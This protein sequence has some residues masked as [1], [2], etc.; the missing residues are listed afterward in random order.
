MAKRR[1]PNRADDADDDAVTAAK[2]TKAPPKKRVARTKKAKEA[3]D[4]DGEDASTQ[5]QPLQPH[6]EAAEDAAGSINEDS[7]AEQKEEPRQKK[8]A[9]SKR[10][11]PPLPHSSPSTLRTPLSSRLFPQSPAL[12]ASGVSGSGEDD[13]IIKRLNFGLKEAPTPGRMESIAR[14]KQG[15]PLLVYCRIR[16]LSEE[17]QT[18]AQAEG[19]D[20]D[21]QCVQ[22][23]G[24]TGVNCIAPKVNHSLLN[25]GSLQT[26]S[27]TQ[28]AHRVAPVPLLIVDVC[29]TRTVSARV[30][31]PPSFISVACS[32]RP[33]SSRKCSR[34]ALSRC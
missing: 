14:Q 10:Q 16:P 19:R 5:S 8:L 2:S 7:K 22:A 28:S 18:I 32:A 26:R 20:S 30:S 3:A 21:A 31:R 25:R 6:M 9:P 15:Q 33:P 34:A 27:P 13:P 12:F 1:I 4:A 29:R 23:D 17:E 24:T 11:P